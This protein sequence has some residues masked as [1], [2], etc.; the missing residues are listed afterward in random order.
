MARG[1]RDITGGGG[2]AGAIVFADGDDIGE[3]SSR[4][5]ETAQTKPPSDA[6][7]V[8]RM[9]EG[10]ARVS[11]MVMAMGKVFAPVVPIPANDG[12]AVLKEALP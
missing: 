9:E 3:S 7:V 11:S 12:G 2:V 10:I 1:S 4:Q 8:G 6:S 5:M